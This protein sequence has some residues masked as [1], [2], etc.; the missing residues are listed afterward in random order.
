MP[1]LALRNFREIDL[2][3]GAAAAGG[4]AG[5]TGQTRRAHVLN[6]GD[7]IGGEQFEARF[8]QQ[9]FLERIADLHRRPIF[10]RFLG[11]I[12][13]GERRARQTVA[14][15]LRADVKDRIANAAGRAARELLVPQNAKAK[16]VHERIAFEA[17]VE[18]NLAADGRDADAI[19]V[20]RDAGDHA[21]EQAPIG[22]DF[23]FARFRFQIS[24]PVIGPKRS[25]LSRNSGRAPI[26]KM[27]RMI[28]PT[29]VAAPWNGSI[30]LG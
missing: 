13:R 12:A 24:H 19:A 25:E 20:M 7:R 27:S 14:P 11:Q 15:R 26:V 5:R 2:D 18:I 29:P 6:A 8:E 30:A 22:G 1:G 21:G 28:P 9:F 23:E 17:F 3:A 4:F 10:A 16:N